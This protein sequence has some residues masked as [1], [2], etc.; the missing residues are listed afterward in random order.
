MSLSASFLS[1]RSS[2]NLTSSFSTV[3]ARNI[4]GSGDEA[5]SKKRAVVSSGPDGVRLIRIERASDDFIR[6]EFLAASS[7]YGASV[8]IASTQARLVDLLKIDSGAGSIISKL[9]ALKDSVQF[10]SAS[11]SETSALAAVLESARDLVDTVHSAYSDVVNL[12]NDTNMQIAASVASINQRIAEFGDLDRQIASSRGGTD[13]SHLLDRREAVLMRISEEIG[14]TMIDKPDGSAAIYSTGGAVLYDR[15]AR[16]VVVR[17]AG[18][19]TGSAGSSSIAIDGIDVSS[20]VSNMPISFGRLA[21]LIEVRDQIVP[22]IQFNIDEFA[23]GLVATFSEG[24]LASNEVLARLPGLFVFR[25]Q[26]LNFADSTVPGASRLIDINSNAD[27]ARGGSL[28]RIRDGGISNPA[29]ARYVSNP[30]GEPGYSVQLLGYVEA[31]GT[32]R[33]FMDRS[34]GVLQQSLEEFSVQFISDVGGRRLESQSAA[35]SSRLTAEKFQSMLASA[36][37]V[38]LDEEMATLLH[39]ENSYR[40]SSKLLSSINSLYDSLFDAIR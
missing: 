32:P 38:N 13:I 35:D 26:D 8:E 39:L 9:G 27:P 4:E 2:L 31:I 12:A 23:R 21:G 6:N 14:I 22:R 33:S 37:E 36:T 28:L 7:Q 5:Y 20:S 29:D 30:K 1:A 18:I 15:V 19:D 3:S 10:A 34:G 25:D 40:A 17:P 16:E 24:G 11:P